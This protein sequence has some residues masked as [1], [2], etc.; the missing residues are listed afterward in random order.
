VEANRRLS[1][2]QDGLENRLADREEALRKESSVSRSRLVEG[3]ETSEAR[4]QEAENELRRT[5]F[6]LALAEKKA[7][8]AEFLCSEAMR[9]GAAMEESLSTL[10]ASSDITIYGHITLDSTPLL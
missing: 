1:E 9:K 8:N 4:R 3:L 6:E 5:S 7:A 2:A 10:C